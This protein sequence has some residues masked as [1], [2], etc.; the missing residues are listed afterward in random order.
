MKNVQLLIDKMT[1]MAD[2]YGSDKGSKKHMYTK[3][4]VSKFGIELD[5][6]VKILEFGVA[7]GGSIRLWYE[8]FPKSFVVGVDKNPDANI[9]LPVF[10]EC[11]KQR[12]RIITGMQSDPKILAQIVKLG[13]FDIII[14]DGSHRPE[15]QQYCFTKLFE[16]SLVAG[17][18]YVIEDLQT[19]RA[20]PI[21]LTI[22]VLR[23][24]Q[25]TLDYI[26]S[27]YTSNKST[28]AKVKSY[29]NANLRKCIMYEDKIA[30][31]QKSI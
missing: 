5:R 2:T 14:D 27:Y 16:K 13:P 15:D 17:G 19:S 8:W 3:Y 11:D 7:T 23:H 9:D 26:G 28:Q 24:F 31:I 12:L 10:A 30:F 21:A 1:F 29:I 20:T 18:M 25:H 22:D 4:Y 6:P